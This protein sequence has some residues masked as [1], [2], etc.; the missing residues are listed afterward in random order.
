MEDTVQVAPGTYEEILHFGD[1]NLVLR[2]E[3][4]PLET[5]IEGDGSGSVVTIAGGQ[6][7]ITNVT[8]FTITGGGGTDGGGLRIDSLSSPVINDMI[9]VENSADEG[10][11]VRLLITAVLNLDRVTIKNK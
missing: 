10:A 4:G 7:G 8:G 9:I 6:T 3:M 11:G 2:S 1:K 5:F